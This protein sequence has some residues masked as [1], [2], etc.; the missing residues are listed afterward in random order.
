MPAVWS[1]VVGTACGV[2]RCVAWWCVVSPMPVCFKR[3]QSI[4][5]VRAQVT[6]PKKGDEV[7]LTPPNIAVSRGRTR[8][9]EPIVDLSGV[10][11][12]CTRRIERR[13]ARTRE[14]PT[15]G[16]RSIHTKVPPIEVP[17]N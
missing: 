15:R 6:G 12:S 17:I 7:M 10:H 14:D 5:L 3:Q 4:E 1:R 8:F 16:H 2:A 9:T 11:A 13:N